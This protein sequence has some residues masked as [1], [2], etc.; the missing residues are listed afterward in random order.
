MKSAKL[1]QPASAVWAGPLITAGAAA[2]AA[3]KPR[4]SPD[5]AGLG[6]AADVG[7]GSKPSKSPPIGADCW[8]AAGGAEKDGLKSARSIGLAAGTAG[9][10]FRLTGAGWKFSGS[11]GARALHK[12]K[13]ESSCKVEATG[14]A[15]RADGCTGA[16]ADA[17]AGA[18]ACLAWLLSSGAEAGAVAILALFLSSAGGA[19]PPF[20][21]AGAVSTPLAFACAALMAACNF[22]SDPGTMSLS[23]PFVAYRFWSFCIFSCTAGGM[24]DR[25]SSYDV[26]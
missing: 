24:N 4:R 7:A 15:T 26:F 13:P 18:V 19:A 23:S 12:S 25:R 14:S 6:L 8:G 2:G 3:V 10:D 9:Q 21:V 1:A 16:G 20:D 17:G 11:D 5:I 22:A